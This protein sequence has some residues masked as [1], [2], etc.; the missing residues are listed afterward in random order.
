MPWEIE[1]PVFAATFRS[2]GM[3][4]C[5]RCCAMREFIV[6]PDVMSQSIDDHAATAECVECFYAFGRCQD[7]TVIGEDSKY[8]HEVRTVLAPETVRR[9]QDERLKQYRRDM[10]AADMKLERVDG[11]VPAKPSQRGG[12]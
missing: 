10:L 9:A 12:R 1:R 4:H 11:R 7:E 6:P 3:L 5:P 2:L 8:T